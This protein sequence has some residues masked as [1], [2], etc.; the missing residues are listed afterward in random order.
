MEPAISFGNV[1]CAS[2]FALVG[3]LPPSPSNL[4]WTMGPKMEPPRIAYRCRILGDAVDLEALVE[5]AFG[6]CDDISEEDIMHD[7]GD[8]PPDEGGLPVTRSA[9]FKHEQNEDGEASEEE[10]RCEFSDYSLGWANETSVSWEAIHEAQE[11]E[12]SIEAQSTQR[13]QPGFAE[14]NQ[15][16]NRD[17]LHSPEQFPPQSLQGFSRSVYSRPVTDLDGFP[18]DAGG[19]VH[20]G[21]PCYRMGW[22]A[23]VSMSSGA[24]VMLHF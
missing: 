7:L 15:T 14:K 19:V 22:K 23:C 11:S 24:E 16:K 2:C 9:S 1:S 21:V 3:Y 17:F 10:I 8:I 5:Q 12:K 18:S 20:S 4:D 6:V 13:R